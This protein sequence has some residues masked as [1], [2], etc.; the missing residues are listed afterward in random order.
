MY[1]CICTCTLCILYRQHSLRNS[2]IFLGMG[3]HEEINMDGKKNRSS[4]TYTRL[5][6]HIANLVQ[7]GEKGMCD[8]EWIP[9]PTRM[10]MH[11]P[12]VKN[13]SKF[14]LLASI[15][16]QT[17]LNPAISIHVPVSKQDV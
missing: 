16:C 10:C 3:V 14:E 1:S 11:L 4:I 6:Y 15:L 2:G 12:C 7:E 13:L 9:H 5:R 8:G 17:F